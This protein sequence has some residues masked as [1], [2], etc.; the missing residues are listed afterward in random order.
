MLLSA[1]FV[2]RITWE[3]SNSHIKENKLMHENS[4]SIL[5][6]S[7]TKAIS[8]CIAISL[9]HNASRLALDGGSP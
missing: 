4:S 9:N 1:M 7:T 8:L 6:L 5:R 3:S 2:D